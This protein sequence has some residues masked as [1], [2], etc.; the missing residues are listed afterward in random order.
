MLV[1]QDCCATCCALRQGQQASRGATGLGLDN[2]G[3]ATRGLMGHS[4]PAAA[5]SAQDPF[6]TLQ[7]HG[8]RVLCMIWKAVSAPAWTAQW[9]S[10]GSLSACGRGT[11]QST[12]AA[13]D[14]PGSGQ[15]HW[16]HMHGISGCCVNQ[17]IC[18]CIH[19]RQLPGLGLKG[20]AREH[21]PAGERRAQG[22]A[23]SPRSSS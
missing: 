5:P 12:C 8:H 23:C 20:S 19:T 2:E 1:V 6:T 9:R 4:L 14:G 3:K 22:V 13:H 7:A 21:M 16:G 18:P 17:G 10:Q 15:C 11:C